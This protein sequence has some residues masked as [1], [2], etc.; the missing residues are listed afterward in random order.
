MKKYYF[1]LMAAASLLAACAKESPVDDRTAGPD[2]P[3]S[4]K[5]EMRFTASSEDTKTTLDPSNG[6]AILWG[7]DDDITVFAGASASGNTFHVE[8]VSDNKRT[9]VFEGLSELSDTYYALFPASNTASISAG[10]VS[11]SLATEQAAVAGTFAPKANLSVGST[12]GP[13]IQLKNV[14]ALVGVTLGNDGITGIKLEGLGNSDILSGAVTINADGTLVSKG[15]GV[16]YVSLTGNASAFVNGSTY[17]FVVLPGTYASGLRVTLYKGLEFAQFSKSAS[18][19]FERN[20]NFDFGT[21]TATNWLKPFELGDPLT[22]QGDGAKE[23]GQ[24][25]CYVGRSGYWN[26]SITGSDVTDYEYNYEIFTEL[27]EGSTFYFAGNTAYKSGIPNVLFS[28]NA[29]GTAVEALSAPSAAAYRVESGGIY[30]IRMNLS[31]MA[32]EVKKINEMK[33][34]LYGADSR[35][36]AY[37]G[38]GVWK[39]DNFLMRRG[40]EDYQNRYRF[41]VKFTDDTKQYYGRM[42]TATG[43][44]TYGTTSAD[45]FYLQP[46]TDAD[47]WD[48]CFKYQNTYEITESRYYCTMIVAFNNDNND[49]SGHY[50][51]SI[52]N[53]WDKQSPIAT[54]ENVTVQGSGIAS[55][56]VAGTRMRYSTSFYNNNVQNSGDRTDNSSAMADPAGY[57]YEIFVK[58]SKDTKFYF[59]AASGHHFAINA[60]GNAIEGIFHESEIGYAGVGNDGVY[61]VRINSSNG[62]VALKRAESV[63]YLQPDRGTNQE[64]S[65]YLGNGVWKGFPAF[66]WTHLQAWGN[67]ERFKFKF[68]IY[69]NETSTWQY[70]GRYETE[71]VYTSKHIQPIT[72]TGTLSSWNNFLTVEGDPD[73]AK[74]EYQEAYGYCDLYLKLNADGYT[75][76]ITNIRK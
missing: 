59:T 50:T 43:N 63:R 10:V 61:R 52:S 54:G 24:R 39:S 28:L 74:E 20:G 55:P 1:I 40:S 69:F 22:I 17:Y 5:V 68:Q 46:S 35:I 48:P 60:A 26:S 76:E 70:Y 18:V 37:Q 3:A 45:Y 19:T 75:Y 11:A 25:V 73:L 23:A 6:Y 16:N 58:L 53:I 4:G 51:H 72:D 13:D 65:Y 64:L 42:S 32:A 44:P 57:D 15:E 31:T 38:N 14:G 21:L 29:A 56:D 62:A 12:T 30:R 33:Y 36:L 2:A 49:D 67:S 71:S 27:N 9:A 41:L 8:S 47:H 34:D 7:M 66:G